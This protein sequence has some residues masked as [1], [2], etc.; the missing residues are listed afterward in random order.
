MSP[1]PTGRGSR[2]P[3]GSVTARAGADLLE[4]ALAGRLHDREDLLEAVLA[5]VVGVG[6]VEVPLPGAS[7]VELAQQP[8]LRGRPRPSRRASAGRAGSRR[9][10]RASGRS[11][12]NPR[13]RRAAP[14]RPASRPAGG[15]R[16]GAARRARCPR[17][18][19]R[20]RRSRARSAPQARR[21]DERA[22]HALGRRRAADVAE[23]DE[24]QTD[25]PLCHGYSSPS[26]STAR[27]ASWG[28]STRPTCFIRFLPSF[29]F[30][31][32][33][34]LRVMSPP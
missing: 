27:K 3:G 29:C 11:A 20:C 18:R 5:A 30:A 34:F 10:S 15:R 19:R 21:L 13:A 33:F 9:P 26:S 4:Q 6:H 1:P 28:T 31:S 25:G 14:G 2:A 17:A 16:R 8:H 22:H 24:Q 7:G 23:A 32:S 12:R